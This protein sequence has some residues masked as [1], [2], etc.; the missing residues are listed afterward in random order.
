MKSYKS[1][2]V[3]AIILI[4]LA[5]ITEI[6]AA[7]IFYRLGKTQTSY[8]EILNYFSQIISSIFMIAGV[9]IAVW[10]YCLSCKS[11][12]RD[13][14][15]AQVQRA[16]DMS[17]Y[18]KDNILNSYPAIRYVFEKAD[19]VQIFDSVPIDKMKDFDSHELKSLL[20]KNQIDQLKNAQNT[21]KFKTAILE[22]NDIYGLKLHYLSYETITEQNGQKSKSLNVD[23]TSLLTAFLADL[24]CDTLNN[25][26]FFALHF[27]HNTADESVVY[28]SLHQS[29]FEIVH[30]LY[31]NIANKNEDPAD[32]LYTNVIWLFNEW[33]QKKSEQNAFRSIT[34][35]SVPSAGTIIEK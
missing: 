22:A 15:I 30:L 34:S 10:Q 26:E 7:A 3:I 31:Y 23:T 17:S 29:Y 14:A 6:V 5:V 16:I 13:L 1:Q 20:S 24:L 8:V 18:Y 9:V 12:S 28:Q 35:Q 4:V 21:K 2:K 32:K 25:L 11:T 27:R 19:L 33:K